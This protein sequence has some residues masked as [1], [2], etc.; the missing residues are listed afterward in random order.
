MVPGP[1]R[2]GAVTCA[3][4]IAPMTE[5]SGSIA[6]YDPH[7]D[8]T[9]F[10]EKKDFLSGFTLN[11]GETERGGRKQKREGRK[12]KTTGGV[13]GEEKTEKEMEEETQKGGKVK[14][15]ERKE[16]RSVVGRKER[17]QV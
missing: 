2:S 13:R 6:H 15:K 8:K 1:L 12:D 7:T 3:R 9:S 16:E 14:R 17:K 4:V 11:G 10:Q 5:R